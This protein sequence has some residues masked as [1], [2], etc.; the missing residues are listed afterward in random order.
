MNYRND[1]L[2]LI[3][4]V[5]LE[6]KH[7]RILLRLRQDEVAFH[8][9]M[10]PSYLSDIENGRNTRISLITLVNIAE[11]Y[12]VDFKIIFNRAEEDMQQNNDKK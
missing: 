9:G 6:L 8:L 7:Q 3:K 12:N 5:C 11:F 10:S 1:L 2:K 4:Y